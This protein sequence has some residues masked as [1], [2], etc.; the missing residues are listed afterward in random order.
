MCSRKSVVRK[1][2]IVAI[3]SL[4]CW[5]SSTTK[6]WAHQTP[7]GCS[8][9]G[10][11]VGLQIFR[12][13]GTAAVTIAS[14]E[15]VVYKITAQNPPPFCDITCATITFQCPD[16]NGLPGAPIIVATGLDLPRGFGQ[17]NPVLVG[18]VTC[19]VVT[20]QSVLSAQA[21]VDITGVV[22]DRTFSECT[23]GNAT[24]APNDCD[25]DTGGGNQSVSVQVTHP[26]IEVTKDCVNAQGEGG[27]I[28]FSGTVSN[29]GDEP[30]V[31][32]SVVDDRVGGVVFSTN[33]LGVGASANFSGQYTPAGCGPSTNVATATGTATASG[34]PVSASSVPA[35]C[36]T[37]IHPGIDVTKEC[38]NAAP[39]QPI[40]FSGSVVNSG[41]ATLF[42]VSV[43]DTADG[44]TNTV[45]SGVTLA[46]NASTN[47]SG[48]YT[49]ATSPSTDTAIAIGSTA[50]GC[51]GSVT[52]TNTVSSTCGIIGTPK[53]HV[54]KSCS[55][56]GDCDNPLI[57]FNGTVTNTGDRDLTGVTVIDDNGTPDNAA[58]DL[59]VFGPASLP[60]GGTAVFSGTY[61][62]GNNPSTNTVVAIA[63]SNVTD[64]ASCTVSINVVPCISVTE[65]CA[66]GDAANT[67]VVFNGV[68]SNC[69]NGGL[70]LTGVTVTHDQ[71]GL[72]LRPV[73]LAVGQTASFSGSYGPVACPGTFT[74]NVTA[75]GTNATICAQNRP[76]VTATAACSVR[77]PTAVGEGCRTTG[78]GKQP[79][80]NTCPVINYTTHGGQVGAPFG[81]AGAPDCA[82]GAGFNNP[83]ISGEYQHVRHTNQGSLHAA[84]NGNQ[85]DFDSLVCACLPCEFVD[86]ASP[87]GGCHPADRTYGSQN[88][89]VDGLCNPGDRICGPEPR[90]APANKICFSG[91]ADFTPTNGKRSQR[92]VFRVDLEDRSEPGGAH[93][94]GGKAPPD[95]YRM[96]IWFIT[97]DEDSA[98]NRALRATIACKD[99]L[100]EVIQSTLDCGGGSII[101]P[102]IDDG[103]DLDR[104]NSQIHPNTGATCD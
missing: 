41:D 52:K 46:P 83:C 92:V 8:G 74:G 40:A 56:V 55:L 72:V 29:C 60:V 23:S 38:Q 43:L 94:R 32:V 26:C 88:A 12:L 50:E 86:T 27:A 44:I 14:G 10:V 66:F 68:V 77:C 34:V 53:I 24:C 63:D 70:T 18:A 2:V 36:N 101:A 61:T 100:T 16:T 28:G 58:D 25:P 78:G 45:L 91:V 17:K 33:T 89:V 71:A 99:P 75:V 87:F 97:G 96:R 47:F 6:L 15:Q 30:L 90:K 69:S 5:V 9:A 73:D 65:N 39:G 102:D 84:G 22:H 103:G 81:V 64:T 37:E 48:Q 104:G 76:T 1:R 4:A 95:R 82:T 11:A 54:T 13:D 80:E 79:S 67:N 19:T 3:V 7:N 98:A 35:I 49:P 42:N 31:G 93:P 51:I 62:A 21:H 59:V 85:H 57:N 20:V